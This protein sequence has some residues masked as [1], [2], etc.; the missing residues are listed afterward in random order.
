MEDNMHEISYC[1]QEKGISI[2]W[3]ERLN[4]DKA[5]ITLFEWEEWKAGAE[6]W[7][8]CA[9]GNQCAVI[10][11]RR[12]GEPQDVELYKL[13][14]DFSKAIEAKQ[15]KQAKYILQKIEARSAYLIAEI[16]KPNV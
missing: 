10:P 8:T 15:L 6:R 14:H 16:N 9:V 2:N 1:K 7:P 11:R 12:S 5:T 13:G 3:N 4:R